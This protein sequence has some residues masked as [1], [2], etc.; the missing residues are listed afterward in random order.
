MPHLSWQTVV[1]GDP[2]CAP[3]R[4]VSVPRDEIDEGIDEVTLLPSLF[5][6]RRVAALKSAA[7]D[8]P[9][10][11]LALTLR[12]QSM[13]LRGDP[14]AGRAA[15]EEAAALAPSY[16]DL[17][18]QLAIL[19]DQEGRRAAAI[20][21]YRRVIELEPKNAVALN[22]LAYRLA[23]EEQALDEALPLALRAAELEP[24]SATILD[25]LAWI[26]HLRGDQPAAV[27]TMA[28]ALKS[29]PRNAEIRL[30]AAIIYAA[31]GALGVAQDQLNQ[32]LKLQPSLVDHPDVRRLRQD[33]ERR[34]P[35]N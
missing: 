29:E 5:S 6:A 18:L 28:A 8:V 31:S 23:V 17:Q 9:E 34:P 32:A 7:P 20:E 33:L 22:N 4:K 19:H 12:G 10:R 27:K 14:V 1:I 3:F 26:Q 24:T 30:H 13:V 16:V 15:W 25:T 35:A 2:L 11:A 21:R